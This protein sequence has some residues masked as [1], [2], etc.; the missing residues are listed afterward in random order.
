MRSLDTNLFANMGAR[1]GKK[2]V[3]I[4][5]PLTVCCLFKFSKSGRKTLIES[6]SSCI[7]EQWQAAICC[8]HTFR[9]FSLIQTCFF[10]TFVAV[11]YTKLL[12]Q[13]RHGSDGSLIGQNVDLLFCWAVDFGSDGNSPCSFNWAWWILAWFTVSFLHIC[14]NT[15]WF[16]HIYLHIVHK[17]D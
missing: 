13:Q 10:L 6:C 17:L 2:Q 12:G 9:L 7:T 1:H 14:N 16:W 3:G 5:R 8:N 15:W 11:S 4:L